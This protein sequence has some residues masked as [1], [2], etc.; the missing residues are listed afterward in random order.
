MAGKVDGLDVR[1]Q[2][3]DVTYFKRGAGSLTLLCETRGAVP[4]TVIG[5]GMATPRNVTAQV[6]MAHSFEEFEAMDKEMVKGKIVC[7]NPPLNDY[8]GLA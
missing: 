5:L 7:F 4:L 1:T 3:V 6:V 2:E 8:F